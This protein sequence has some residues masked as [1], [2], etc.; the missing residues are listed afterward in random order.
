MQHSA[1]VLRAECLRAYVFGVV[2]VLSLS[3]C[4]QEDRAPLKQK[5][6][7]TSRSG[8]LVRYRRPPT[9]R[10]VE[11]NKKKRNQQGCA[12]IFG[13]SP[14]C[15]IFIHLKF[16]PFGKSLLSS[17]TSW[18]NSFGIIVKVIKKN[19]RKN[20]KSTELSIKCHF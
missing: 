14:L 6:T 19:R 11:L 18:D 10:A 2:A 12:A 4:V 13:V 5:K 8:P 15:V 1:R 16:I 7:H 20:L 3:F 9:T 17:S